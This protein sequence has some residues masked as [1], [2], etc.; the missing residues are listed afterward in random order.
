VSPGDGP[1]PRPESGDRREAPITL[2]FETFLAAPPERVF[3]ALTEA[4]HLERWFCDRA[5]SEP[6]AG[7]RLVLGW[8]RPGASPEAYEG[9]W[10]GFEPARACS[11]AGG[12][13]G[14][15]GG[16]A[17]RIDHALEPAPGGTRL[18]TRHAFPG[19]P[20]YDAIARRY[21]EAWPRALS[22]LAACLG[23]AG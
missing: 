14:Y 17:G 2:A 3:A 16:D 19:A 20:E 4:R 8:T 23:D 9:R 18:V 11:F 21:R 22:R 6:R 13:A 10:L 7:G 5:V 12:H 1:G 15:P